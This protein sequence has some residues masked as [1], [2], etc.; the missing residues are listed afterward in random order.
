[1]SFERLLLRTWSD[2]HLF[3]VLVELTYRCNLD[4][5]FCYNDLGLR[6]RPLSVEQYYEFFADLRELQV[7]N[8]TLSGGEPLAHPDF[9]RL[10][11][12]ARELGFVVRIKSN[13]HALRGAMARRIRDEI[14]PFL[15]EVSLHGATAA[16]HDRQTREPGSF[17]RL[18]ANLREMRGLGLR[19]KLNSTLT[20]W[21]EHEVE[22]TMALADRL[23]LPLQIDPEVSPR[24]DGDR[25]PQSIS[26]SR[27]GVRRLFELLAERAAAARVRQDGPGE[28]A[29]PGEPRGH[30]E[31]GGPAAGALPVQVARLADDGLAPAAAEKHCGAGSSGIA[32]DPYGNVYP[33]VQWRRPVGNLHEQ[34]IRDIWAGSSGLADVRSLTVAAK[35]MVDGFGP[36]GQLLNFCPGNADAW[37]GNALQV[38]P[39][40]LSRMEVAQQAQAAGP[41]QGGLASRSAPAP[42]PKKTLLP[43]LPS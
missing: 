11:A 7:L 22:E 27:A 23:E 36:A 21:N 24:D 12:R 17:E 19:V 18:L 1:M 15:V 4:C 34:S 28:E 39:A 10:G 8:L 5:F 26:P 43:I 31:Q 29:D 20:A 40:A 37:S 35:K 33:C 2:N 6:G 16:V 14:D 9:L 25:E 13:G 41:G 30:R 32:V 42:A 38:Y 3:S